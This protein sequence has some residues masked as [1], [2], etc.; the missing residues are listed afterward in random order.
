MSVIVCLIH[1]HRFQQILYSSFQS[2]FVLHRVAKRMNKLE[3]SENST[4]IIIILLALQLPFYVDF[5]AFSLPRVFY[6]P[7]TSYKMA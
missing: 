7:A 5:S 1:K 4:Y 6:N 2:I 3:Y